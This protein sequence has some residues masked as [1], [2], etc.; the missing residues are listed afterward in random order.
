MKKQILIF[1]L[2][3]FFNIMQSQN[4]KTG[5]VYYNHIDIHYGVSYNSYLVFNESTSYFVTA[6][7]SLGLSNNGSKIST[8]GAEEQ[9]VEASDFNEVSKTKKEGLQV[10]LNKLTDSIYF[11]NS[12]SLTSKLIYATE[13]IPKLNWELKNE[14]KEIGG[15]ICKKAITNF[16]GREYVCWYTEEIPLP[17]GPWKLQGLPGIIMEAKSKDGFFEI[18]FKK[19]KYPERNVSVPSSSNTLLKNGKNF[20]SFKD[21]K[22][23]QAQYIMKTDNTLR[24]L[25]KKHGVQVDK[26]SESDNFLEVLGDQ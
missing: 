11:A 8:S 6:K 22:V 13:E 4:S 15:F 3:V 2:I 20:I 25:A 1:S 14:S 26:F 18:E 5:I 10:Y 23:L 16:R 21:Y 9:I 24:L 19:I 7:D 17:Y 12:F